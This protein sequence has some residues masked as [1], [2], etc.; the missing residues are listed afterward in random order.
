MSPAD[1]HAFSLRAAVCVP[2][3]PNHGLHCGSGV[4]EVTAREHAFVVPALQSFKLHLLYGSF[5][6]L[7]VSAVR[8]SRAEQG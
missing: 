6:V 2:E 8:Y 7:C 5:G 1:I 3:C 4:A